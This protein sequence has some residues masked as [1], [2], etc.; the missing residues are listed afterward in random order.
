MPQINDSLFSQGANPLTVMADIL[1]TAIG[2]PIPGLWHPHTA[3]LLLAEQ[4]VA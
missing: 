2:R 4:D 1:E 3:K